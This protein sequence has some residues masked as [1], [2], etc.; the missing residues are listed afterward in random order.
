MPRAPPVTIAT[1][2]RNLILAS[3]VRLFPLAFPRVLI[4][5]IGAVNF[6]RSP[7][8]PAERRPECGAVRV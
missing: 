7:R 3:P 2:S 6:V 5:G 1:L 4:R 8:F